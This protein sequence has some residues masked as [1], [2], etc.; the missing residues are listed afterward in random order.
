[1]VRPDVLIAEDDPDIRDSF[2]ILLED[3]GFQ[4]TA[5]V[6][7]RAVLELLSRRSFDALVLDLDVRDIS[8]SEVLAHIDQ[9]GPSLPVFVLTGGGGDHARLARNRLV[10]GIFEK[11]FSVSELSAAIWEVHNKTPRATPT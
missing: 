11:P 7:G 2:A 4:T 9:N 6:D 1:V 10:R 3:A 8:G 5:V